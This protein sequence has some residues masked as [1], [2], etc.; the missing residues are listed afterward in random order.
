VSGRVSRPQP[1][2]FEDFEVGEVLRSPQGRTIT[3]ADNVW[4]T[5]LTLNTNQSHFNYAYAERT[6]FGKPLV[7]SCLTLALVTGLTVSG[8]SEHAVANLGW[9]QVTMPKPVFVGDTLWAETEVL[10]TR[11]SQSNPETGIVTVRSRGIN[12]RGEV[13]IEF[14]RSFMVPSRAAEIEDDFPL[15][16]EGP[17]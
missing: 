9:E 8:T 6:R 13:V 7:N 17:A 11:R 4:F 3:D 10:A 12:Q 14:T 15:V 16:A 1:R 5:C 2:R